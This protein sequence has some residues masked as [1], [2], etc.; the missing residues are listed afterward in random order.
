MKL[1]VFGKEHDI[2]QELEIIVAPTHPFGMKAT[3]TYGEGAPKGWTNEVRRNLTEVHHLYNKEME[4]KI[5]MAYACIQ[6]KDRDSQLKI[7]FES[8]IHY[9]GMTQHIDYIESVVV[10]YEI[11]L[12]DEF[13][14]YAERA[15]EL[16]QAS[17]ETASGM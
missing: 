5:N 7:A 2:A 6:G 14:N 13:T 17:H 1:I 16:D 4:E 9:T 11:E 3:I 10:E 12:S 8:D 15:D